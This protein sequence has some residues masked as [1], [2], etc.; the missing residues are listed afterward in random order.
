MFLDDYVKATLTEDDDGAGKSPPPSDA[1][2]ELKAELAVNM[3]KIHAD[4]EKRF[5]D[6]E[7][8][9]NFNDVVDTNKNNSNEERKNEDEKNTGSGN[10]DRVNEGTEV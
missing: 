8:R 10:E 2:E 1:I 4:M 7:K 9:F 6:L 5:S 3:N